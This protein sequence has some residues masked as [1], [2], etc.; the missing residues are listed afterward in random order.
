MPSQDYSSSLAKLVMFSGDDG[1]TGNYSSN[2]G[3]MFIP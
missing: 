1:T 3:A 2:S